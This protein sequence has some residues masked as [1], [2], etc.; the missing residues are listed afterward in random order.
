MS[1]KYAL[2][3]QERVASIREIQK[4]PSQAL[5]GVTRVMRGSQTLGFFLAH[6]DMDDLLEDIEAVRSAKFK[7]RI[8]GAR[9]VLKNPAK[10]VTLAKVAREYGL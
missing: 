9:Q 6:A 8:R 10:G 7:A 5:R 2:L 1:S 3:G 4:N